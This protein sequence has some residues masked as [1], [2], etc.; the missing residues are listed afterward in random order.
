MRA[1]IAVDIND[2]ARERLAA[3][4]GVLRRSAPRL[5]W[6]D[7][8]QIHLTLRFL[9]DVAESQLEA[10]RA[11]LARIAGMAAPFE[12]HI[13]KTGVFPPT[14]P[15]RVVWV[16]VKEAS[17]ALL[18]LHGELDAGLFPLGFPPEDRPFRPHL[19]LA[20]CKDRQ[21]A[22]G[23]W[24]TLNEHRGFDAGTTMVEQ[25]VLYQSTLTRRGPIYEAI[26]KHE[27]SGPDGTL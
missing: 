15:P 23:L 2:A 4:Q 5:K 17:G 18:R 20:R 16:G 21:A 1:F 27:F 11:E 10:I 8:N 9:G 7:P 22:R 6:V 24:R 12:I 3:L 26:S 25:I 13:H 19:T 14:G